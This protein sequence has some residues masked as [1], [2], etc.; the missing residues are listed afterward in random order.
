MCSSLLRLYNNFLLKVFLPHFTISGIDPSVISPFEFKLRG[1][2]TGDCLAL[3][4]TQRCEVTSYDCSAKLP[5]LC[6]EWA[7][8]GRKER[9]P[10]QKD[11]QL[12]EGFPNNLY[13]CLSEQKL[14]W[15]KAYSNQDCPQTYDDM[16]ALFNQ[17]SKLADDFRNVTEKYIW[18]GLGRYSC[19]AGI[20]SLL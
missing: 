5:Y 15:E 14:T 6:P 4:C 18:I 12:T 16:K 1:G 13:M 2:N 3:R 17:L 19:S 7:V 8:K 11:A 9:C 10:P 20:M